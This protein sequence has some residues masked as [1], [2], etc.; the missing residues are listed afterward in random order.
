M[1]KGKPGEHEEGERA[2]SQNAPDHDV[3]K[4]SWSKWVYIRRSIMLAAG[5]TLYLLAIRTI[6]FRR[7]DA[8]GNLIFDNLSISMLW[9]NP[10]VT[11][12][13]F[14]VLVAEHFPMERLAIWI[15]YNCTTQ[16]PEQSG[17]LLHTSKP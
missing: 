11:L 5:V 4:L 1:S 17:L 13:F 16:H 12:F 3:T 6:H 7:L 8:K 15:K 2:G 9:V 10:T 14:V